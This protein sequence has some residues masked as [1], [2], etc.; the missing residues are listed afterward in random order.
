MGC[1]N[2][3]ANL[4]ALGGGW[5]AAFFLM[6]VFGVLAG[7]MYFVVGRR[8]G[9]TDEDHVAVKFDLLHCEDEDDDDL[10]G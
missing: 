3:A 8:V 7:F 2:C 10:P 6:G 5:W 1:P 9:A 4:A